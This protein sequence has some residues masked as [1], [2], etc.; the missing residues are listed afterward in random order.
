M[1]EFRRASHEPVNVF[2][3]DGLYLF[4]YYVQRVRHPA[5]R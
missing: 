4:K 2:E 3:V 5:N 1:A